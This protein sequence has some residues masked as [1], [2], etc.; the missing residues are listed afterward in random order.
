MNPPTKLYHYTATMRNGLSH[1][2]YPISQYGD[3]RSAKPCGLWISVEDYEDDQTWK[4]WCEGEQYE[5]GGLQ[6]RYSIEIESKNILWLRTDDELISFSEKYK[7]NDPSEYD[8]FCSDQYSEHLDE[9]YKRI[10]K[11]RLPYIYLIEWGAVKD[12]YDGIIIAPYSWNLRMDLQWYYGWDCASGCI[13]NLSAIKNF[14]L[15][16]SYKFTQS[17]QTVT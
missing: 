6:Y 2:E 17:P 9:L 14:S 1:I 11:R 4:T 7:G 10:G 8:K 5:I 12:L 15:D 13:W 3:H 16:T